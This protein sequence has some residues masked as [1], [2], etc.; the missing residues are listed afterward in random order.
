MHQR[1]NKYGQW[2]A[3][4]IQKDHWLKNQIDELIVVC[5]FQDIYAKN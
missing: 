1:L 3:I 2:T 5:I 4:D